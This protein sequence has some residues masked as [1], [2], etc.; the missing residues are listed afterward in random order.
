[1]LINKH[2][3]WGKKLNEISQFYPNSFFSKAFFPF[4]LP[5]FRSLSATLQIAGLKLNTNRETFFQ[6]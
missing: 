5:T 1:M 4:A 2:L 6:G 3:H